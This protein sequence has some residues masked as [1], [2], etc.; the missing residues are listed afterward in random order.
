MSAAAAL[1][2]VHCFSLIHDDLPCM[3]DDDMR[4][5]R[6]SNHK[7]FGEATALL[8]GDALLGAAFAAVL[9][10]CDQGVPAARAARAV[11]RLAHANGSRGMIGGQAAEMSLGSR[12][13]LKAMRAMHAQKTGAL[14]EA[15]LLMAADLAG[16]REGSPRFRALEAFSRA[17]GAAFQV[18]DDL[19]DQEDH[20]PTSILFYLSPQEAKRDTQRRLHQAE[21]SLKQALGSKALALLSISGEV[22]RKLT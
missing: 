14:F 13:K 4:R 19:E 20:S 17:L 12:P 16:V 22:G 18:V 7:K 2:M 9:D 5:G 8:A 15:A 10:V 6:P 1:E 3:D 11:Q 21:Q